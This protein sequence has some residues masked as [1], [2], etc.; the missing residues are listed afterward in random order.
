MM[1]EDYSH[2]ARIVRSSALRI[3]LLVA[4]TIFVGLGI[5]GIV[6]PGLPTTPFLL[7]AAACYARSSERFYWWL[8]E[9]RWFGPSIRQWRETKSIPSKSKKT[10]IVLVILS[11]G[12]TIIFFAPYIWLK[13][14]L[15]MMASI[16]L[17]FISRLPVRDD[18]QV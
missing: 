6:V 1:S 17:F 8:L 12:V 3:L 4:G 2:T 5:I 9:N 16:S 18:V 7:L 13:A 11:F 10:A 14:V 15:L